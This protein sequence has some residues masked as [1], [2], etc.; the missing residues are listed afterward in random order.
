MQLRKMT[1][2][3]RAQAARLYAAHPSL[4]R[5]GDRM[6]ISHVAVRKLL[7]GASV[8]V[9]IALN[10]DEDHLVEIARLARSISVN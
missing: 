7:I 5:V 3:R 4:R 8:D 1:S 9:S 2:K 6:G 10:R